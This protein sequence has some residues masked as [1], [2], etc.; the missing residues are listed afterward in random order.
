MGIETY[1]RGT[2]E[3]QKVTNSFKKV[4]KGSNELTDQTLKKLEKVKIPVGIFFHEKLRK[5]T[6]EFQ[7]SSK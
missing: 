3:V 1:K 7:K 5:V 4:R 2:K 6:K